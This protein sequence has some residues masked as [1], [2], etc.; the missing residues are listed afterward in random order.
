MVNPL[1]QTDRPAAH[2]PRRTQYLRLVM[3]MLILPGGLIPAGVATGGPGVRV[4]P[5][6]AQRLRDG[7]GSDTRIIMTTSRTR[8]EAVVARHGLRLRKWLANGAAVDIPAGRP[9]CEG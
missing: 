2:S 7:D 1:N 8:I 6:L 9:A 3:L 4:S 5:D